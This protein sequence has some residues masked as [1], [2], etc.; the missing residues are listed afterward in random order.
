MVAATAV[1]SAREDRRRLRRP[2]L[3]PPETLACVGAAMAAFWPGTVLSSTHLVMVSACLV[4][5][6]VRTLLR[7]E[8]VAGIPAPAEAAAAA[9]RATEAYRAC[10]EHARSG[11][12][13][14]DLVTLP[15]TGTDA[16][17]THANR[18]LAEIAGAGPAG[19]AD[20]IGVTLGTLLDD[21]PVR[22]AVRRLAGGELSDWTGE[23]ALRDPDAPGVRLHLVL[24]PGVEQNRARLS[25]TATRLDRPARTVT[26]PAPAGTGSTPEQLPE[27]FP[28]AG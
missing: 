13:L 3:R 16:V 19:A 24:L 10:Y 12:A 23:V 20:L 8:D 18:A 6:G 7:L 2:R 1:A 15:G 9:T 27:P 17:I 26:P 25:L 5:L 14:L 11:L 22:A 21:D 4:P 28:L